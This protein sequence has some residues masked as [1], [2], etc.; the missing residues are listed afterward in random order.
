MDW[1]PAVRTLLRVASM[2]GDSVPFLSFCHEVK[3]KNIHSDSSNMNWCGLAD[4]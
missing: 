4:Q 2:S 1:Q 3:Q